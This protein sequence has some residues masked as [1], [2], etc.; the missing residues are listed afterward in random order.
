MQLR[1]GM[2][3][4]VRLDTNR[5]QNEYLGRLTCIRCGGTVPRGSYRPYCLGHA[6]YA[7]KVIAEVA[8]REREAKKGEGNWRAA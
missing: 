5:H 7:Q 2:P 1:N 4:R 3:L 6:E 8:R